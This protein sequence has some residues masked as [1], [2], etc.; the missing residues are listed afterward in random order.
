[1][2]LKT[3]RQ[4]IKAFYTF[5]WFVV[6]LAGKEGIRLVDESFSKWRSVHKPRAKA[7]KKRKKRK[8]S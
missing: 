7:T 5:L 2:D 3:K 8:K 6:R 1:M 4:I